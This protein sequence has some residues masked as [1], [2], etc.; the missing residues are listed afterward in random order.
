M[1]NCARHLR[2]HRRLVRM[3]SDPADPRWTRLAALALLPGGRSSRCGCAI[4][5]FRRMK[6]ATVLELDLTSPANGSRPGCATISARGR[7]DRDQRNFHRE[8]VSAASRAHLS[9][10]VLPSGVFSRPSRSF[11]PL[12]VHDTTF[13][14]ERAFLRR[15]GTMRRA[16]SRG[17]GRAAGEPSCHPDIQVQRARFPTL[18]SPDANSTWTGEPRDRIGY[19][20]AACRGRSCS[21]ANSSGAWQGADSQ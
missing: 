16:D 14:P 3:R 19:R 15:M 2:C 10:A 17:A 8:V 13:W 7:N 11:R 4:N 12:R 1:R 20:A 21:S 9:R 6:A 18:L 5:R